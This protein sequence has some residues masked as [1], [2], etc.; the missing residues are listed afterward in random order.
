MMSCELV[1]QH[2]GQGRPRDDRHKWKLFSSSKKYGSRRILIFARGV[3]LWRRML[4]LVLGDVYMFM[5]SRRG[6]HCA[7]NAMSGLIPNKTSAS[8]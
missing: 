2:N 1:T 6:W 5:L 7:L 3:R 4:R 8:P